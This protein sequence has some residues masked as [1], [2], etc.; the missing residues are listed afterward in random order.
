MSRVPQACLAL[1]VATLIAGSA[2]ADARP[3]ARPRVLVYTRTLGFRHASIPHAVTVLRALARRA[4]LAVDR[5]ESVGALTPRR[6]RRDAAVVFLLTSGDVL[7]AR[8]RRALRAYVEAGGGFVGVHS[9]ADTEHGWGWYRGLV[10]AEFAA[11]GA[12]QDAV[13]V[14]APRAGPLA[15]SL[16]RRWRRRDEWYDFTADPRPHVHVLLSLDPAT[17][18]GSSMPDHPITWCRRYDGGR[19]W[20]SAMGHTA[21]GYDEPG[22]R[23]LLLDG[24]RWAAG[25]TPGACAAR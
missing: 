2:A 10:G 11:H 22:F 8:A 24:L 18:R 6:L 14:R 12:V 3:D 19:S 16:P 5:S 1:M 15:G 20:Y 4:G 13:V 9:A 17:V 21:A 23:R 25:L 7:D